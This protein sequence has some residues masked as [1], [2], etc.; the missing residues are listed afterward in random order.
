MWWAFKHL[1]DLFDPKDFATD[2][3]QLFLVYFYVVVK[4]ILKNIA[5]ALGAK[6]LLA[7][8]KLS[9]GIRPIIV[10]EILYQLMNMTLCF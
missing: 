5:K 9:S 4:C 2:F 7:L 10:G 3:F 1:W 6:R 8:A